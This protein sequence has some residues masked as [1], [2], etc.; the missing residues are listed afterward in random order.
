MR[1]NTFETPKTKAAN[2]GKGV[3]D[4]NCP[5]TGQER[6]IKDVASRTLLHW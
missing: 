1:T 5:S 4:E 6:S 3:G 2:H